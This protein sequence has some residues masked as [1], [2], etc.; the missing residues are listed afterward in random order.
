MSASFVFLVSAIESLTE[1]GFRRGYVEHD[2]LHLV[3]IAIGH[4]MRPKCKRDLAPAERASL[5][6]TGSLSDY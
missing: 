3:S 6:E 1:R 4:G 5:R 2:D